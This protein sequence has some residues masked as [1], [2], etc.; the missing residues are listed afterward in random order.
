MRPISKFLI[1]RSQPV[2][3]L[4]IYFPIYLATD[5]Q[6][7][8]VLHIFVVHES[9]IDVCIN[10]VSVIIVIILLQFDVFIEPSSQLLAVIQICFNCR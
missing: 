2:A 3:Y 5:Q 10:V 8:Y 1:L 6:P 7:K 4:K 9:I